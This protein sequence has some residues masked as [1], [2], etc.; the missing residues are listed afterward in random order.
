LAE[1]V[2][3]RADDPAATI[4]AGGTDVMVYLEA[5]ALRPTAVIDA[6]HCRGLRWI[7]DDGLAFGATTTFAELVR[8]P[9]VPAVLKEV[10]LTIGAA[11]IQERATIGG[12]VVNS[13]PAGDSLPAWLALD[14]EFALASVRGT[15]RVPAAQF[16]LGYK[17]TAMQPDEV[18]AS[19]TL[20]PVC[21]SVH[22]RK[23]GTRMAQS[24]SK[25]VFCGRYLA[26]A[27]AR[28]ALGSVAA[29]PVRLAGAEAA[30][31][32]R[33][34]TEEVARRVR[35]AIRPIDDVRSTAS[36]RSAVAGNIVSQ[37][38]ETLAAAPR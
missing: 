30:L 29:T 9:A 13:S 15:R 23:V 19:I 38:M 24:I 3:M 25:V 37:W 26:G 32:D 20:P 36:Y 10:A 5:G 22:F 8:H 4:V 11:Q 21:G 28:I 6:W 7:S 12:N 35:D 16:W 14:A 27:E 17:A 2:A 1:L 33:G 18:L 31:R 34:P